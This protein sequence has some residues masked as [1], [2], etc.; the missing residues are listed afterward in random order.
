MDLAAFEALPAGTLGHEFA[1]YFRD[2]KI[3][4]FITTFEVSSDFDYLSK[5]YRETHD[6]FHVVTGYATD[7]DGEME[8]QAFILGNIGVP[9]SALVLAFT[10][11]G[12][13]RRGVKALSSYLEKLKA[14]YRRGRNSRDL[15]AVPYE[16]FWNTPVSELSAQFVAAA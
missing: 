4:P 9:S 2:N 15:L 3:S 5:R 16:H 11:P 10:A 12:Y 14:A 6:L 13:V 1:R 7:A 8:L